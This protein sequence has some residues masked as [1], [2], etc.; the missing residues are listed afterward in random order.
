MID[1]TT[2]LSEADALVDMY[3]AIDG[4]QN[5]LIEGRFELQAGKNRARSSIQA[6]NAAL[7]GS[8]AGAG[9]KLAQ[10]K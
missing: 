6:G 10:A 4:Q 7:I 1:D 5:S 8:L 9:G 3:S 2:A